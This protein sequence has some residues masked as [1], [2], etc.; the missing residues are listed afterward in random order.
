MWDDLL[1]FVSTPVVLVFITVF[2]ICYLYLGRRSNLPPGPAG[3]PL[4]G[5][6]LW[7][8]RIKERGIKQHEFLFEASKTYG[9]ILSLNVF[10]QR[11]IFLH[12]FDTIRDAFVKNGDVLS[13]RPSWLRKQATKEGKG[14][15]ACS[16]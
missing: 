11:F 2:L 1:S 9:D 14:K 3:F 15:R 16:Q 7:V 13:S 10:G 12:G 4:I 5:Y 8:R 6:L